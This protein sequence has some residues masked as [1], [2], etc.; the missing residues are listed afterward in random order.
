MQAVDNSGNALFDRKGRC[1]AQA[2]A[3]QPE[4][5]DFGGNL[6]RFRDG[7]DDVGRP[8]HVRSYFVLRERARV[9]AG[10]VFARLCLTAAFTI[11]LSACSSS[12]SF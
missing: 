2:A 3:R 11:A 7:R 8:R 9:V 5:A 1:T 12:F 6:H 10:R 4:P